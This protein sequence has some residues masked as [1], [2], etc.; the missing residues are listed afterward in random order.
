MMSPKKFHI[1]A[2]AYARRNPLKPDEGE[3]KLV[4]GYS[5]AR[6]KEWAIANTRDQRFGE[7]VGWD[8]VCIGTHVI[9]YGF[10]RMMCDYVKANF[11]YYGW[12]AR[13]LFE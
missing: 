11:R 4:T 13:K 10:W 1:V 5:F 8:E 12:R 2:I 9:D 3:L 6:S 7:F